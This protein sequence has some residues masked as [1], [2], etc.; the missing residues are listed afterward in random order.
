MRTAGRTNNA[1]RND[2]GRDCPASEAA[3]SHD[4]VE[5]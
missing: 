5:G 4:F 1:K 3:I 2:P